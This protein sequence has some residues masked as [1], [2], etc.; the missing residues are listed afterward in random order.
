MADEK[1]P[2]VRIS[3]EWRSLKDEFEEIEDHHRIYLGKLQEVSK[4]QEGCQKS[5]KHC[6]YRIS[7]IRESLRSLK[8]KEQSENVEYLKTVREGIAELER[9]SQDMKGELPVQSNGLY[10]SIILG[11]NLNVSLMNKNDRYRY[12]KEYEKFKVTVNCALLSLLFF[13]YIFTS[14]VLDL[15]INFVLVWFYCTLTIR[16]AILRINGSRIKGWWIMH[17]YVSC[18]LSGITVTWGDGE[19][20]RSIRTQFI[21]F[22]FFLAFVQLLQCRY[23]TGCLRRLHAL[24]QRYSMDVSVE[25][26]SSWMFKGLTFLIPFLILTY[27]FQFYNSYKLYYLSKAP[28]CISQWQVQILAYGFFLVACCNMSTL[29][30]VLVNKWK[31]GGHKRTLAALRSKYR[32]NSPV[33]IE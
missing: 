24:G 3:D 1:S 29:L 32:A 9:R 25:G 8:G 26:F 20:Y 21:M 5:V 30:S 10:L 15:A 23:Q 18:V 17:H 33:K 31:Q 2:F 14:R 4:L 19:C 7:K 16:E 27:I 12:K 11:S 6:L 13:A 28:I 22:C